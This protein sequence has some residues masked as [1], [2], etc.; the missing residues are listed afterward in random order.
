MRIT[1]YI[2]RFIHRTRKFEN[3]MNDQFL[4]SDEIENAEIFWFKQIQKELFAEDRSNL[5]RKLPLPWS[6]PLIAL[7]L[8]LDLNG[9]IRIRGRLQHSAL[10]YETKHPI[11]LRS[12]TLVT[13]L[14]RHHHL[15]NF[16]AGL[17]LTLTSLRSKYWIIRVHTTVRS[18][19]FRCVPCTREKAQTLIQLMGELPNVRVNR[20][21]RA[22]EHTGVD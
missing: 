17:S 19:L 16:H 5:S 9:L 13:L 12:H 2:F 22:F 3:K 15:T 10:S 20:S 11:V 21:S 4:T 6:S 18:V 1:A 8:F 14:I 7:N